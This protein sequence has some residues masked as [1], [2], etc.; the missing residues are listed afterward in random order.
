MK[1]IQRFLLIVSFSLLAACG[2]TDADSDSEDAESSVSTIGIVNIASILNPVIDGVKAGMTEFDHIEGE[3]INYIYN[4]PVGRDD[5]ET[6]IQSLID[7]GVDVIVS[8]TTPAS[9]VARDLTL[10]NRIPVV[11]VPVND[12]VGAGIVD[13]PTSPGE[14]ITGIISGASETRRMEW[15]L[16]VVP[17]A[18]RIYYPY[19]PDDPSPVRTLELFEGLAEQLGIEIVAFEVSTVELLQDAINNIPDDIDAIYLPS[20]SRVGSALADWV[21]IAA[22]RQLP[23]SGSS[24]AHVD[25][26][27]LSSYSYSPFEAGRQSARLID[28]IL[29]G[30]DPG[31]LPVETAEPLFSINMVAA[32]AIGLEISE[33]ILIQA[34]IIVREED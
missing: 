31:T 21:A 9:I 29:S 25:A 15:L 13:D 22:E 30:I 1:L 3:D 12:P 8:L 16:T 28:Q 18:T 10:E 11:F 7:Q 6:E 32:N 26:G 24:Q 23:M 4:G 2:A 20:D 27:V 14:N 5:L 33:D 34:N 17:D 19:N